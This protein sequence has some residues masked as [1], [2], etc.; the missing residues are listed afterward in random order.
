MIV[1]S[2]WMKFAGSIGI[3]VLQIADNLGAVE[4]DLQLHTFD[5]GKSLRVKE[6]DG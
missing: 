5:L 3:E 1:L 2:K 6:L 4:L